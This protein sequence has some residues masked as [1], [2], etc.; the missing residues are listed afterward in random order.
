MRLI[1]VL[2]TLTLAATASAIVEP[3]WQ[4]VY[5]ESYSNYYSSFQTPKPGEH[6]A[7]YL[8]I[9]G[10]RE[11]ILQTLTSKSI[12]IA[13]GT[14]S[15]SFELTSLAPESLGI[16]SARVFAQTKAAEA[17]RQ[18]Q[19]EFQEAK[20]K[21]G[22]TTVSTPEYN[23]PPSLNP[24]PDRTT[25]QA[26]HAQDVVPTPPPVSPPAPRTSPVTSEQHQSRSCGSGIGWVVGIV[27]FLFI[28]G[29]L[30]KPTT[31]SVCGQALKR[32]SYTWTIE[33]K[34]QVLCPKCNSRME[35]KVSKE[36]FK[37]KFR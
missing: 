27:V 23:P 15:S 6:I 25:D 30:A 24:L 11:G 34:K 19:S 7:F 20:S 17:T 28:I 13:E 16:F 35:N 33:G 10:Q 32:N 36:A 8:R 9:G 5:K 26:Q 14:N 29:S 4:Q 3:D 31:C 1:A 21:A 22:S 37:A 2:I 12:T 18:K